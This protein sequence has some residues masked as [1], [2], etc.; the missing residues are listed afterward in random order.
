MAIAE[1]TTTSS[2]TS[3]DTTTQES[4][5][6]GTTYVHTYLHTTIFSKCKQRPEAYKTYAKY[7][8]PSKKY[9]TTF[10]K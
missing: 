4:F 8:L 10:F 6:S 1:G 3:E 7:S 9:L 2:T 5:T